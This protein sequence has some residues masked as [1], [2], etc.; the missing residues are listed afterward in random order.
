MCMP[1]TGVMCVA[2]EL[3]FGR[4][5]GCVRERGWRLAPAPRRMVESW[6]E[7]YEWELLEQ[8]ENARRGQ[9]VQIVG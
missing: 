3:R 2:I 1:N 9:P 8:W 4:G 5:I 7:A 6:G